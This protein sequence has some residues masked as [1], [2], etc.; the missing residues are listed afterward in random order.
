MRNY[1]LSALCVLAL[2][3]ASCQGKKESAA[4]AAESKPFAGKTIRVLSMTA[5]VSDALEAYMKDF[6]DATG[7]TVNLELY[8]EAQLREKLMTEFVAG[9]STVDVFL[10]SPLQDNIAF[11]RNGWL[12]PLDDYVKDPAFEWNLFAS[13]PKDQYLMPDTGKI[14][15][16]PL[17]QS[18]Q[19]LYF[20]KDVFEQKGLKPPENYDQLIEACKQLND[21]ARNFY[22][23]ACR[24]EK[25]A[26]TSQ[27]S[28]FLYAF[29]ASY[30]KDGKSAFNTPEALDAVKFYGS[31]LGN[32]APPGVLTA[33]Y[34]QM[35]QLF[36][37]GQVAMAIDA[38]ALYA[39]LT[40]P[41]ESQY[42]D[43]V[44][45]AATPGG[46]KGRQSYNQVVWGIC[47][48]SGSKNKEAGWEFVKFAAG[49]KVAAYIT[50]KGMPSFR[51]SV[52]SDP[53]VNAVMPADMI[54]AYETY[55]KTPT[56]NTFGL[57]RLTSVSEAR[58]AMGEAVVYS[59]Q[60]KGQGAELPAKTKAAA[61]KVDALLKD[62][63]E[64][65]ENY[66]Y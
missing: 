54:A 35:T 14:G 61:E 13:A 57:P 36:N 15:T 29:G 4:P 45:V 47:V 58:D 30:I 9:S 39:T 18:V 19:L 34:S 24:G 51:S 22:A 40:D 5:Q 50:P 43:K 65:G 31:L 6:Q 21:P 53:E 59:I 42:H 55:S 46:P 44:G 27:F 32:Y 1:L 12:E 26:L 56:N 23:I 8:G 7:I 49:P 16:I 20:R 28:S 48:Y 64:Y 2:V 25:I 17:Y 3:F 38:N 37:S 66:R 62:A 33:G 52:W 10:F 63:N 41:A 60:T 11:S